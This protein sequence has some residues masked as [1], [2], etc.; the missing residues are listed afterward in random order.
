MKEDT[1]DLKKQCKCYKKK[2]V[3]SKR[4][5]KAVLKSVSLLRHTEE[6]ADEILDTF[7]KYVKRDNELY[8]NEKKL[9][10]N[11][12]FTK[13]KPNILNIDGKKDE[14]DKVPVKRIIDALEHETG[15]NLIIFAK[16]KSG[17]TYMVKQ[18]VEEWMKRDNSIIPVWF[19]GNSGAPI[20]EDVRK[21]YAFFDGLKPSIIETIKAVQSR[22]EDKYTFLFILDDIINARY[23]DVVKNLALSYRNS[24]M[25]SIFLLQ[26]TTLITKNARGNSTAYLFGYNDGEE[27]VS[28]MERYLKSNEFFKGL[29]NIGDKVKLYQEICKGYNFLVNF[30]LEQDNQKLYITKA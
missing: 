21:K 30:P 4:Y 27:A 29:K 23:S 2:N 10:N 5:K 18:I 19:I 1:I 15:N 6:E 9:L 25:N 20:Y 8:E 16:S 11:V 22:L 14:L 7:V 17:K 13:N 26:N 3:Y 24:K 28:I 12:E